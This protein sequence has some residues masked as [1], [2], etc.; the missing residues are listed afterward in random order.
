LDLQNSPRTLI[1][2][3]RTAVASAGFGLSS[4]RNTATSSLT[5][6]YSRGAV[7]PPVSGLSVNSPAKAARS[8][9]DKVF[10]PGA[11]KSAFGSFAPH[12][13]GAGVGE[14]S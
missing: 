10:A 3:Y 4:W 1:P 6:R 14:N 13:W 8:G 2:T 12:R 5:Q 9:L 7:W 11:A